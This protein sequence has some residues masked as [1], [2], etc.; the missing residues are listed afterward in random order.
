[1]AVYLVQHGISL[2]K[3]VDPE[4]GLSKEG[5]AEVERIA[6]VAKNYHIPE[7]TYKIRPCP[8]PIYLW[9]KSII[10]DN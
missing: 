5:I 8:W 4:K 10:S 7:Q 3:D 2:P 1:M 6:G 9:T